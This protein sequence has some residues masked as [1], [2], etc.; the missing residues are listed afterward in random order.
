MQAHW[1]LVVVGSLS[2]AAGPAAQEQE[3]KVSE[4]RGPLSPAEAAATFVT[5]ADLRVDQ[6]L[7][8]PLVKQ[9]VSL[10]FDE[11]G[12][13]WV[14]NY[15]QYPYPAGLKIL[16][17]DKYWRVVY[18]R[19]PPP[20][21]HHVPGK[22]RITIHEDSDG[23]GVFDTHRVFV[24]G[25]NIATAC[26][27]GRGGVFVLNPPYL[28]FYPTKGNADQPTGPPLVLLQGF[29]IED[30]HSTA[31]SLC[32]G[33]DG[34]LY[35]THGSTVSA[36]ITR[37][38][39]KEAPIQMIG[40]H[41]WRYHPEKKIFEVFAEGG[42]NAF[43]VEIDS[44]GRIF[45]GH[46]GGDTRGFHY[47][48]GGYYRKGFDKHGVLAN[49][50][51]FGFFEAMA[52]NKAQ[53]FSHTF[54]IN[55]A[56]GL[57]ARYRGKLFAVCPLQGHVMMSEV[58]PDRSSVQTRDLEPILTTSDA[59]FRP[60]DIKPGPDGSLYIADFYEQ[61]IAHLRHYEGLI[62]PNTG[63]VYRI[64]ARDA[65]FRKPPD[66]GAL[67]AT[68]LIEVLKSDNRWARQ[69]ALRLLGDRR[70]PTIIPKLRQLLLD[71]K[72]PFALECLW[73]LNLCGGFSG[74]VAMLGLVHPEAAVRAW[75]VRLL[76][77][78]RQVSPLLAGMLRDLA[79]RE[80]SVFV[81]S[82][83]AASARRLPAAQGLPIVRGL[84][85][86]DDDAA[87]IHVP[88]L[89]WWA[90]E[91]N[92][93]RDREAVLEL[94]RDSTLWRT[95]LAEGTILARLMKRFALAGT[96]KD[97]AAC[98]ELFRLAPEPRHGRILLKGFEEAFKGRSSAGLPADLV[99]EIVKLGGGSLAFGV[100]LG[101]TEAIDQA[102]AVVQD[103]KAPLEQRLELIEVLGEIR[104]P[105]CVPVLLALLDRKENEAVTRSVLT[106]L[107]GYA[108]ERIGAE[109]VK[110]YATLPDELR[111]SAETLLLSRREWSRQWLAA[112]AQG[113]IPS[114][115]IPRSTV[116]QLLLLNDDAINRLVRQLWGDVQGAT[117]QEMQAE[118]NRLLQIVG[119]GRG[120]PLPGKKLF[121]A[122]CA[123]CH[124]LH[125]Q[126]GAVG[127]DLT[128][129]QRDD[130]AN[131]M[132]HI[133]N[134][135]AEIREGFETHVIVTESGRTLH[136]IIVEKDPRVV[137]VR[138]ADGQR[139]VV[140][141]DEIESQRIAGTS[142]MPEGLLQGL[143]DQDVRDLFA[144]LRSSQPL[145][146]K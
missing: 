134:P 8:E 7:A 55:E 108:E 95:K 14:V 127:P 93:G 129:Y 138:T 12:R 9:P 114:K 73:A 62:D 75:T 133:V 21:P 41:V 104:Q 123:A 18:D 10:S 4:R 24:A 143:S 64:A 109:V 132:L 27:R 68:E 124:T 115:A 122:K 84:L 106:A 92:C 120:D 110:R 144:Y 36:N 130:A 87:D 37:P 59:W 135:N 2:L 126:G 113:L 16:S 5:P 11:K 96:Q 131:L 77:D 6:V 17:R 83:L 19:M 100:R 66:L 102:L 49:P 112:V 40:Q 42:G 30:C 103:P 51:A 29:G 67:S 44:L 107:Q 58:L 56:D 105:R 88:L 32:W 15:E 141:K 1:L 86:H 45:S 91:A 22:D 89:L 119:T 20:P 54:V 97:L 43:G 140:P 90:I 118:I 25:L 39:V 3:K 28:L 33:V 117:T 63:R 23:D 78:E 98:T 47:V 38:G 60:V 65:R 136:G 50:F 35:G 46:N 57:P 139:V 82:Q 76:G 116:R 13:L 26:A 34:W 111:D 81:R 94:W 85:Q 61:H 142:L 48:Q 79:V 80:S 53:R 121:T 71:G 101:K 74:D 146:Y 69:T 52:H 72:G 128:S 99:R 31:N 70:D 145:N 137:V 125:A